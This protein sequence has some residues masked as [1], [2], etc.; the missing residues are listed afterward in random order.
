MAV[1]RI[2]INATVLGTR[3]AVFLFLNGSAVFVLCAGGSRDILST[4]EFREGIEGPLM[5]WQ[6]TPSSENSEVLVPMFFLQTALASV[7]LIWLLAQLV[8]DITFCAARPSTEGIRGK[9]GGRLS[10]SRRPKV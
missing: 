10:K 2:N 8:G 5:S 9:K 1:R 7:P 6:R 3:V 4:L